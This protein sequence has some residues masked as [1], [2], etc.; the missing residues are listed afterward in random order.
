MIIIYA[1]KKS[2]LPVIDGHFPA[3]T[4]L[5]TMAFFA[6]NYNARM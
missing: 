2:L 4:S 6:Q 1:F 3:G 5:K